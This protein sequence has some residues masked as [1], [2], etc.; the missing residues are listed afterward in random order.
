MAPVADG[1]SIGIQ[2]L[3][4]GMG[5]AI[6]GGYDVWSRYDTI[7]VVWGDQVF[8]SPDTLGRAVAACDPGRNV[9]LPVTR[10]AQ[11]YV[12]Y[13]FEQSRL[14][15]VLQTREG[16]VTTLN[17]FSDVGTFLLNTAGLK[18]TWDAYRAGAMHG[19]ATGEINFLPFLPWLAAQGWNITPVEVADPTE[20]RGINTP[21]DLEFFRAR[22]R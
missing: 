5:D 13:I 15:E 2:P 20:A 4:T 17:G 16:D 22:F 11:P 6:F 10:V 7:L 3:P 14:T 12:E 21:E 1:V 9:A 18:D 19:S 8:V